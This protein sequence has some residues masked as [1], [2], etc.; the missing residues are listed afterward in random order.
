M[1]VTVATKTTDF[2]GFLT[3][4][5]APGQNSTGGEVRMLYGATEMLKKLP[6]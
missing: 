2:S 4:E 3:R 1:A 6:R 5:Q